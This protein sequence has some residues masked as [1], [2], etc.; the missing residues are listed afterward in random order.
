MKQS[1][2]SVSWSMVCGRQERKGGGVGEEGKGKKK[3]NCHHQKGLFERIFLGT[4]GWR[5][6]DVK[7]LGRASHHSLTAVGKWKFE[8]NNQPFLSSVV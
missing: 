4:L 1:M 7:A 3:M 5:C 2:F 8:S 6:E